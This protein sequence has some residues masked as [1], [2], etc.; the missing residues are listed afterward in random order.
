MSDDASVGTLD[1]L[2]REGNAS[3]LDALIALQRFRYEVTDKAVSVFKAR[4]P[5]LMSAIDLEGAVSTNVYRYC[6][7]DGFNPEWDGT[8]GWLAAG[9]WLPVPWEGSCYLGLSFWRNAVSDSAVPSVT[10][11]SGGFRYMPVFRKVNSAYSNRNHYYDASEAKE[12]GFEWPLENP[13]TLEDDLQKMMD[14]VISVWTDIGGWNKL[15]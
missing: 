1:D 2:L 13:L 7:P 9:A 15:T 4:L 6:N 3:Y 12:C 8:W 14:Y 5:E 11:M 10:F